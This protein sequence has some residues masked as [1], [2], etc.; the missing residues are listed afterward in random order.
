MKTIDNEK[1]IDEIIKKLKKMR[2]GNQNFDSVAFVPEE[3]QTL[4][5]TFDNETEAIIQ[6]ED[7]IIIRYTTRRKLYPGEKM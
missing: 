1:I 4:I 2:N 3:T 6:H 7:S 5:A